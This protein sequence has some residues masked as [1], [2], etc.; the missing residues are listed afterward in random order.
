MNDLLNHF[1]Q[2]NLEA[3]TRVIRITLEKIRKRITS[4]TNYS[5]ET[6]GKDH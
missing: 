1:S 2:R 3:I 5:K 6:I 4:T